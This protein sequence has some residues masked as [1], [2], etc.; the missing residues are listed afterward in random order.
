[1]PSD[2][3]RAAGCSAVTG[4]P[5]VVL[6]SPCPAT[7]V[8]A[9]ALREAGIETSLIVETP[10][11]GWRLAARRA[12]RLGL[13]V[14]FGQV[15]FRVAAVPVL[16]HRGRSRIAEILAGSTLD[17]SPVEPALRVGSVNDDL[18]RK[19]LV[20]LD[21]AVVVVVGTRIIGRAT[22]ACVEASFVNLHAG[23]TPRYRGVHGGYWAL[24][25]GRPDLV[26]STV[27]LVDAGIDTGLVLRQATFGAT[28]RDSFATY[29]FL[30]LA[31]GV[32]PL[33]DVVNEVLAGKQLVG[34]QPMDCGQSQLW[35]HPTLW[36]Y[37]SKRSHRGVR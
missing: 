28:R 15:L 4:K 2:S 23:I 12:R 9:N 20:D 26:G 18:T 5:V 30:H 27:H 22:L 19:A 3:R 34:H 33:I 8:V 11:P 1:M 14:V 35:Y 32:P 7:N 29:P 36:G 21:P 25:E 37:L 16:E 13:G 6:A 31:A 17:D 24:V 10:V